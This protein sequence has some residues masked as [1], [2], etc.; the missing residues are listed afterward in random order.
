MLYLP[1]LYLPCC[2]A[3]TARRFQYAS[4]LIW[5]LGDQYYSYSVCIFVI[6]A[7]SITSSAWET[8]QNARRLA[9]MAYFSW[10]AGLVWAG[11]A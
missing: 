9:D 2:T 4:I 8:H 3:C 1:L 5:V 10:C 11:L 7:V 6:T